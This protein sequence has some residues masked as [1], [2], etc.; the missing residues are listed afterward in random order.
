[1]NELILAFWQ[2]VEQH[3]RHLD[4]TPTS[5]VANFR[6]SLKPMRELYG[7]TAAA[8]FGPLS[9][10]AFRRAMVE[11][12]LS[13][14]EINARVS[15]IRLMFKWTV[16]DEMISATVIHASQAVEGL[17]PGRTDAKDRPPVL[18][19]SDEHFEAVLPHVNRHIRAMI[20]VQ[21][22]AGMRPCEVCSI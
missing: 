8:N 9:L 1:M 4:G 20:Q 12:G 11:G 18:P 7:H 16:G 5:E 21:R 2:N 6:C 15:R 10:K 19:V 22:L 3:Y 14:R 17:K 13:R